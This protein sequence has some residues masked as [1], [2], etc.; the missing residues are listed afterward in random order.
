MEPE[1]YL[2]L[3]QLGEVVKLISLPKYFP[4]SKINPCFFR[5]KVNNRLLTDI[6]NFNPDV[7]LFW[8]SYQISGRFVNHIK[9]TTKSIVVVY[10]NDNPFKSCCICLYNR[11]IKLNTWMCYRGQL[12]FADIALYYRPEDE[13]YIRNYSKAIPHIFP[14]YYI[15]D[16]Y[17]PVK[18]SNNEDFDYDISFV[19]HFEN[20]GRDEVINLLSDSFNVGLF[21]T[22]WDKSKVITEKFN[23][24]KPAYLEEY[25]NIVSRSKLSICFFSSLNCDVY[26][27]RIFE[28]PY[29][30]GVLLSEDSDY[31]RSLL[32]PG[33]DYIPFVKK[34]PLINISM[35]KELILSCES[36]SRMQESARLKVINGR[37]SSLQRSE[38]FINIVKSFDNGQY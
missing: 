24:V 21:G 32:T 12:R 15:E 16:T 28:I 34:G 27:R 20:D 30:G 1:I 17:T 6:C 31:L 11:L 18:F 8:N 36:R 33:V 4:K 25:K 9:K 22:G 26:T 19:G 2:K 3:S 10:N 23:T 35:I 38:D 5:R 37:N 29:F 13:R 7:I 14:S